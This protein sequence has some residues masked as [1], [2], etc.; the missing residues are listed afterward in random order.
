LGR[1][2]RRATGRGINVE[3]SFWTFWTES[4]RWV[5]S[6]I[7]ASGAVGA[8]L[9]IRSQALIAERRNV[10]GAGNASVAEFADELAGLVRAFARVKRLG[11]REGPSKIAFCK[12]RIYT[13]KIYLYSFIT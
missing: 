1:R 9:T 7:A 4:T 10:A 3:N 13:S 8:E 11:T 12:Q 2:H 6:R 5:A